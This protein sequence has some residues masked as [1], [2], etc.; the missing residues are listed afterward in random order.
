MS[1]EGVRETTTGGMPKGMT[2]GMTERMTKGM[3]KLGD[4]RDIWLKIY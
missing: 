2:K 1:N 3:T 4:G